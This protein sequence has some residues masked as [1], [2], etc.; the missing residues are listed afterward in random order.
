MSA[1]LA[2]RYLFSVERYERMVKAGILTPD[3]KLELIEGELLR[4]MTLG[5]RHA[6]RVNRLN[7]MFSRL[8]ADVAIVSV[9]NPVRLDRSE[10]EPDIALLR[11][12]DDYYESGHPRPA[13]I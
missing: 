9:Q 3:D 1:Q 2:R 10:P 13:D 8:Y 12:R 7:R 5:S 4:K 6:A 11:L